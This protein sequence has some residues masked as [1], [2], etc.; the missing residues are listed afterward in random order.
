MLRNTVSL[1]F[2]G[3]KVIYA[4]SCQPIEIQV[5]EYIFEVLKFKFSAFFV[6]NN[7]NNN[8][9]NIYPGSPLAAAAFSGALQLGVRT[10]IEQSDWSKWSMRM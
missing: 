1:I 2:T 7:N 3:C 4:L 9:T 10:K 6:N 8:N 5:R